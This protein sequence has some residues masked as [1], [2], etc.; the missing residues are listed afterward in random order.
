M[1]PSKIENKKMRSVVDAEINDGLLTKN[2]KLISFELLSR[3]IDDPVE[4]TMNTRKD[5]LRRLLNEKEVIKMDVMSDALKRFNVTLDED[6]LN[7]I[8]HL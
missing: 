4:S 5:H 3:A 8:Y 2:L 1:I 7:T 6:A